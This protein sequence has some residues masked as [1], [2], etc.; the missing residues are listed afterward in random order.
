V[1]MV[2]NTE[3]GLVTVIFM[4]QTAVDDRRLLDFD[5]MEALLVGLQNGSAAIIGT[6]Q[7]NVDELHAFIHNSIVPLTVQT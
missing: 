6:R 5:D 2:M 4:P 3:H 1:H 7:Q